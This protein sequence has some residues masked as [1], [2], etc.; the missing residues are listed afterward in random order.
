MFFL[1]YTV[2]NAF[3]SSST[4]LVLAVASLGLFSTEA[5]A[6]PTTCA[7]RQGRGTVTEVSCDVHKRYNANGHKVFDV[8]LFGNNT[9]LVTSFVFWQEQDGTPTYAEVFQKGTRETATWFYTKNGAVGVNSSTSNGTF[10]F[11]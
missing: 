6:A 10:Y 4:A 3:Y 9:Q 5:D 2:L 1:T 8:T 11:H 7:Y